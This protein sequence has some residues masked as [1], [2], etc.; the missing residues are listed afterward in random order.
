[1]NASTP[2][3]NPLFK[4][5]LKKRKDEIETV[6]YS[7]IP[8]P[9]GMAAKLNEAIRYPLESGGKRIRPILALIGAEFCRGVS[10]EALY[11][12]NYWE[13]VE[14]DLKQAILEVGCAIEMLHTYSLVHDDLPCMD[15]DDLRRGRPTA[16]IVYGEA[17]A[18]L[19]AD[20]LNTLGFQIIANIPEQFALQSMRSAKELAEASGYPGMVAGQVVDLEYEKK[21]GTKEVLDFIHLH[22][23]AALIRASLLIGAH[24]MSGS[25]E[26]KALLRDVG[27][28]LG[29]IFQVVDD[30][31]D[32]EG[33]TQVLGKQVGSDQN[34][35]K[36]T[37]PALIGLDASKNHV[38]C[39]ADEI[40]S[41]LDLHQDRARVLM[42]ITEELVNRK[43]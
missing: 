26:D 10:G 31:L 43:A 15:D 19:A 7:L 4:N 23:T 3:G 39:L 25:E 30:I 12:G 38:K 27:D 14:P 22:K 24:M 21:Q 40:F 17:I 29:L 11:A 20:A 1:M 2:P 6:L 34:K 16:H 13:G 28:K 9:V 5:Y 36:L 8:E 41:L 33:E 32:V 37:Y 18:V 42:D 35:E